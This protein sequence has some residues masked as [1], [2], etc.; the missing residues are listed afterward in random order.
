L[1]VVGGMDTARGG[2][3]GSQNADRACRSVRTRRPL[4]GEAKPA[5][6]SE[7]LVAQYLR[8]DAIEMLPDH[9]ALF[10]AEVARKNVDGIGEAAA[11]IAADEQRIE[12]D[13][14]RRHRRQPNGIRRR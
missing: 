7:T 11:R 3:L 1:E 9:E 8:E 2:E 14:D 12:T 6:P 5:R 4:V 13:P 10:G